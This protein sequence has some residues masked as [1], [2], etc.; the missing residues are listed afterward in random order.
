MTFKASKESLRMAEIKRK[1]ESEKWKRPDQRPAYAEDAT[2]IS[3]TVLMYDK[4]MGIHGLGWFNF[5]TETWN[6]LGYDFPHED[7][8]FVWTEL[9]KP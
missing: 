2:E 1:A 9:E 4:E 7:L 3:V 5:D 6:S 8:K